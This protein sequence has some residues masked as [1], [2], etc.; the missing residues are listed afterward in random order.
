M[1]IASM[2]AKE[3]KR[4]P[5]GNP[6]EAAEAMAIG[7]TRRSRQSDEGVQLEG[8]SWCSTPARCDEPRGTADPPTGVS[9]PR[10]T[11]RS[12]GDEP[13]GTADPPTECSLSLVRLLEHTTNPAAPQIRR[14]SWAPRGTADP[15]TGWMAWVNRSRVRRRTPR[16]RRPADRPPVHNGGD[17]CLGT[18]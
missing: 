5:S 8:A 7:E 6:T 9:A 17:T 18:T 2:A 16:H 12:S 15:P 3:G 1:A 10:E 14:Q 4:W 11:P 13:R